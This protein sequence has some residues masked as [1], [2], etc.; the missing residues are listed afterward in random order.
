MERSDASVSADVLAAF[1]LSFGAVILHATCLP[2]V[3]TTIDRIQML[4]LLVIC[5][6]QY[7]GIVLAARGDGES[8]DAEKLLVTSVVLA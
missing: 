5:I 3:S 8:G 6:T 2:F 1:V 7:T 4:S